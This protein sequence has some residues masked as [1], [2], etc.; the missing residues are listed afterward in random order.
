MQ[1]LCM[2]VPGAYYTVLDME[3]LIYDRRGGFIAWYNAFGMRL[4][5][6]TNGHE[7]QC[8]KKRSSLMEEHQMDLL[9]V[10]LF[11]EMNEMAAK[12]KG[13]LSLIELQADGGS[14]W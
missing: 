7:T 13:F 2:R 8:L 3:L 5:G 1:L 11:P 6:E 14:C 4:T 12:R 10:R 9:S